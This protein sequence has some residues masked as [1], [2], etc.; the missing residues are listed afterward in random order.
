MLTASSD[1]PDMSTGSGI[2][3]ESFFDNFDNIIGSTTVDAVELMFAYATLRYERYGRTRDAKELQEAFVK[4]EHA[5]SCTP[6]DHPY[7]A[8]RLNFLSLLLSA[9]YELRGQIKDLDEAI[10]M[11][12][13]AVALGFQDGSDPDLGAYLNNLGTNLESRLERTGQIKDLE[14]AAERLEQAVSAVPPTHPELPMYLCNLGNILQKLFM[15][16]RQDRLELLEEAIQ[17]TRQ[18]VEMTPCDHPH[19]GAMLNNLG[20]KFQDLFDRTGRLEDLKDAIYWSTQAIAATPQGHP[21][22]PSWLH[23]LG[24]KLNSRFERTGM[25]GDLLEA[26]DKSDQAVATAAD[27][28]PHRHLYL[29]S[30]GN[31][32]ENLFEWR[33]Q[34]TDLD[35][36]I[37]LNEKALA[38]TPPGHPNLAA[39]Q[40][41]LSSK[42]QNRYDRTARMEDLEEAIRLAE[43][44][45]A[46]TSSN[47]PYYPVM[48]NNLG[49]VL[50]RRFERTEQLDYLEKAVEQNKEALTV[51][52]SDDRKFAIMLGNLSGKL[53]TLFER[54]GQVEYLEQAID[55]SRQALAATAL[56]HPNRAI[57]L[58]TLSHQLK[59]RFNRS[60][61]LE[62]LE[63][64]I[65][66]SEQALAATSYDHPSRSTYLNE[67][68]HQLLDV[69]DSAQ[70]SRA[71]Q[72]FEDS[73][74]CSNAIPLSRI[75]AALGAIGILL[76]KEDYRSS[77]DLVQ[78]VLDFL[79]AVNDRTL[80]RDDQQFIASHLSGLAADACS[81]SLQLQEDAGSAVKLLEQGRGLILANLIDSRSD[82]ST[83]AA[84]SPE[85]AEEFENLRA[86]L[87]TPFP[88]TLNEDLR[89]VII[90]RRIEAGRRFEQ[91]LLD[92]RRLPRHEGFL[93][94]PTT[95][96]LKQEANHGAVIIV[97]TTEIRSDAI[98]ITSSAIES[99]PLVNFRKRTIEEWLAKN[100]ASR[101][102]DAHQKRN[103]H[104][105]TFLSWLWAS[106]VSLVLDKL[107]LTRCE[108]VEDLPHIWW[109]G[110]GIASYLPFHAAGDYAC[111]DLQETILNRAVC[112]Y[113][114]TVKSLSYCRETRLSTNDNKGKDGER[115]TKP[116]MLIATMPTTPGYGDLPGATIEA[117][118]VEILMQDEFCVTS[119]TH[120]SAEVILDG[121]QKYDVVHF[122]CHGITSRNNPSDSH[123]IL[124][125][126]D[127][128]LPRTKT[129]LVRH[130]VLAEDDQ[131]LDAE[132]LTVR[133]ISEH[134]SKRKAQIAYLSA[135]ST[136][137]NDNASLTDEALHL[138]SG[139]QIAGFAH[140]IGSM[141]PTEDAVCVQAAKY[142]YSSILE[143]GQAARS[144]E[145]I[146]VA[147]HKTIVKLQEMFTGRPLSWAPYIH[148]GV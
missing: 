8:G 107:G 83:V 65:Q 18:A 143:V 78:K 100:S 108:K 70:S 84:L 73:W 132:K 137:L 40:N 2:D 141:W 4:A 110:V 38:A 146:A 136:A 105:S 101:K 63:A 48:R 95:D 145:T 138:A 67:L 74:N 79:P 97:N 90:Q 94:G 131:A 9:R 25:I 112:S 123:L 34:T 10:Q 43:L 53:E 28:N 72:A 64:A 103:E 30:L 88:E 56:D 87:N 58:Y 109:I 120:P 130:L 117:T 126:E 51:I 69:P 128:R 68:A 20:S 17:K 104:F 124:M 44:A 13:Q 42:L 39:Y 89:R 142:F 144:P 134:F 55:R 27:D 148:Y 59:H 11:S 45:L 46:N 113:A 116:R 15:W 6:E 76:G 93:R 31:K 1:L 22:L 7:R 33:G 24:N 23:N 47:H 106:C 3:E 19:R 41:N 140:V 77:L 37:V 99:I 61:K 115:E 125:K 147:L 127:V 21:D 98:I 82:I 91:C 54:T 66:S 81:I 111:P 121:L 26:I 14:A 129:S 92:I 86:E 75:R 96:Q 62:D 122:A 80:R 119:I 139:F 50:Q 16:K 71:L 49:N 57:Y 102:G 52:S 60:G 135:C 85:L 133:Q 118:E 32:L 5:L 36:A 29:S 12:E 114:T 35:R